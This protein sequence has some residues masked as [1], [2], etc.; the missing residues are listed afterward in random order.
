MATLLS[1]GLCPTG[2]SSVGGRDETSLQDAT[3]PR[4]ASV[5]GSED[6]QH[7]RSDNNGSPVEIGGG[8]SPGCHP[9]QRKGSVE[10]ML[11]LF[12]HGSPAALDRELERAGKGELRALRTADVGLGR[13]GAPPS[14]TRATRKIR[15]RVSTGDSLSY[16]WEMLSLARRSYPNCGHRYLRGR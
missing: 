13:D 12:A 6:Q 10:R 1:V 3:F 15:G 8:S 16:S 11:R 5:D 14:E 7:Q 4:I 9:G 2:P